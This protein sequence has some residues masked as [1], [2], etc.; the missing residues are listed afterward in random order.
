MGSVAGRKLDPAGHEHPKHVAMG[1]QGHPAAVLPNPTDDAAFGL[2]RGRVDR[3]IGLQATLVPDR[4]GME[5][6]MRSD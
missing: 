1:E 3:R 6:I 5:V 2:K 4:L